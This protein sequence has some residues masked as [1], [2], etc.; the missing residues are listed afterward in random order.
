MTCF[1]NMAEKYYDP[2]SSCRKKTWIGI[3]VVLSISIFIIGFALIG[4]SVNKVVE[5]NELGV[6]FINT[7][8]EFGNIYEQGIHSIPPGSSMFIFPRT[9]Q[10][11]K[12]DSITCF[13]SDKIVIVLTVSVQYQLVKEHIITHI[14]KTYDG[15]DN[16]E[17]ILKYVVQNIIINQCGQ[18][19]AE[20]Y[21]VKRAVIDQNMYQSLLFDVNN[22]TIGATIEFFQLINIQFPTEFSNAIT[23]K[24]IVIQNATTTLNQRTS[25]L[26]AANTTVLEA[27]RTAS[28]ILVNAN[29]EAE[30]NL[31]QANT[32]A[33]VIFTQWYQRGL[34]F[35]S[36]KNSLGLNESDFI[37]YLRSEILRSVRSPIIGI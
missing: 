27:Q 21:Y 17:N 6:V 26:I 19:T 33:N 8:M 7:T 3:G 25:L 37:E 1:T 34:A 11:V 35:A 10:D 12:L 15:N 36:I 18:Y 14:L 13:S 4:V 9:L 30:I 29:N 32:T 23:Q 5:N 24:Q 2:E 28:I 20:D 31:K 22:V 16:F